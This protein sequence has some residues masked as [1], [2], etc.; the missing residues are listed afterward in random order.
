MKFIVKLLLYILYLNLIIKLNFLILYLISRVIT[1][2][3][4]SNF[5]IINDAIFTFIILSNLR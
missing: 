1:K 3:L 5:S 4:N 2:F